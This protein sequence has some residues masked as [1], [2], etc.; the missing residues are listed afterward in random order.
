MKKLWLLFLV[1]CLTLAAQSL[2]A[3]VT[4]AD[5]TG[6]GSIHA[7]AS[8]GTARTITIVA[9][10]TNTASV[11]IGDANIGAS[12]GTPIA[13]GAAAYFSEPTGAGDAGGQIRAVRYNLAGIYYL[14]QTGDKIAISYI[15]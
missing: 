12:R 2:M 13:A 7:I 8:S 5:I 9:L 10:S 4:L 1:T 15:P 6:D 14:V 11:R 3:P